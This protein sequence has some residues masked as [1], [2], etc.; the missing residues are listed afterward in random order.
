[1]DEYYQ[2]FR[3]LHYVFFVSWMA[4]LFYQPRLYVYHAENA[5]KPDFVRVV[6]VMEYK[7]YKYIGYPAIIGSF[8]TGALILASMPD[9]LKSG[10]IHLKLTV[11]VIMAAYHFSLG[12][13]M[14]ALKNGTCKKD[15]MFFRAYNEVP[16][17]GLLIIIWLI[18]FKP[19]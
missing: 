14:K 18:V 13:F 6:E 12:Y 16:T 2:Y 17:V 1:M 8:A 10:Y 11:V 3:F 9:L 7:M 4:V 15:G 19:F 5:D